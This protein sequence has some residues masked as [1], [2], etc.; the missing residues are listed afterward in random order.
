MGQ[1]TEFILHHLVQGVVE[2]VPP[3]LERVRVVHA[4]VVQALEGEGAAVGHGG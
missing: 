4:H 2:S 3:L 1:A